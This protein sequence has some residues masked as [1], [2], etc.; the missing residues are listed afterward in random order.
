MATA[1]RTATPPAVGVVVSGGELLGRLVQP[2]AVEAPE[3][4]DDL[5]RAIARAGPELALEIHALLHPSTAM[6]IAA[7]SGP[8]TDE[9]DQPAT[10]EEGPLLK[11][12]L[13][14]QAI[15]SEAVRQ[16]HHTKPRQKKDSM[17][18]DEQR[19]QQNEKEKAEAEAHEV[20]F[21][22]VLRIL[23]CVHE[24][25]PGLDLLPG[26]AVKALSHTVSGLS[27]DVR[28]LAGTV[29][30]R[31]KNQLRAKGE[32]KE[33]EKLEDKA[34]VF[35]SAVARENR[36]QD[37]LDAVDDGQLHDFSKY[38]KSSGLA[39]ALECVDW[40]QALAQTGLQ[41]WVCPHC[42]R[43]TSDEPTEHFQTK[44]PLLD[45]PTALAQPRQ[46][47]TK[48]YVVSETERLSR[49]RAA[50]LKG[51]PGITCFTM[52][53]PVYRLMNRASR[54]VGKPGG[55]EVFETWKPF[56]TLLYSELQGLPKFQGMVYRAVDFKPP[57]SL[58]PV[59]AVITWNQPSSASKS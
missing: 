21:K 11:L 51:C 1:S 9:E 19:H 12:F 44:H 50:G 17:T 40:A 2:S 59:G 52:E 54:E 6:A 55:R 13:Q 45:L 14:V 29:H 31:E 5:D 24:G 16:L 3:Y 10:S 43:S 56:A 7:T 49:Q 39:Q 42:A 30:A 22:A 23:S 37:G 35:A 8:L 28:T 27:C 36:T 46:P 57:S 38:P 47:T 58:F 4:G 53:T 18:G 41:F 20:A 33:A 15:A 34:E 25:L 48:E 32:E 26:T